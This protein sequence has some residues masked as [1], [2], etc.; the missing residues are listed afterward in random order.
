MGRPDFHLDR[1][2]LSGRRRAR[3][4]DCRRPDGD[5]PRLCRAARLSDLSALELPT[6]SVRD[7][8]VDPGTHDALH[9]RRR[10]PARLVH[11]HRVGVRGGALLDGPVG[12]VYREMGREGSTT[13]CSTPA[14]CRRGAVLHRHRQRLRLVARLLQIPQE[15]LANVTTWGL[16]PIGVGMFIAFTFLVVGCFLD[17]I[18]AIIIVG[19]VLSRWPSRSTCI[20][21]ISPSSRSCRWPSAW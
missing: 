20:Q 12:F 16:G 8:G 18:P 14:S 7:L 6:A 21:S 17:A 5:G 13:P 3:P 1:R 9:H 10:H 2:P 15:L 11:R 19:T 4:A